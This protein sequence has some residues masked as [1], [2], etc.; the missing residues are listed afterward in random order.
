MNTYTV[1]ILARMTHEALREVRVEA[2]T[3]RTAR[4]AAEAYCLPSEMPGAVYEEE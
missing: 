1:E 4:W 3:R 2:T